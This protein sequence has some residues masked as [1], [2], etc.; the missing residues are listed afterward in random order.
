MNGPAKTTLL[1]STS[2]PGPAGF[3]AISFACWLAGAVPLSLVVAWL[4]VLIEPRFAPLVVFPVLV[5]LC[6]G[7]AL[8]GWM[9]WC[10]MAHRTAPYSACWR[11]LW[12]S[13]A[14]ST[15]SRI[16]AQAQFDQRLAIILQAQRERGEPNDVGLPTPPESLPSFMRQTAERGRPLAGRVVH[17]TGVWL[18]WGL[19]AALTLAGAVVPVCD[20]AQASLLPALP[21]VV[22]RGPRRPDRSSDGRRN[23]WATR[24]ATGDFRRGQV[25]AAEL[26]RGCATS[27]FELSW[28]DRSAGE[29]RVFLNAPLRE[30]VTTILD[31][32]ILNGTILE[33]AVSRPSDS[34][35]RIPD[36]SP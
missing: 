8:A 30:E 33:T 10:R 35:H 24:F 5:G 28:D 13:F 7:M 2:G 3:H 17:G 34:P 1:S 36:K 6:L 16:A 4:A 9:R 29:Q 31:R 15:T 20:G 23:R 21:Y 32:A 19:E 14:V 22:S 12:R 26:S 11:R 25:S 18:W 27:V